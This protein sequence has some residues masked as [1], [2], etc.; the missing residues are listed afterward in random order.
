MY[1][2]F[3]PALSLKRSIGCREMRLSGSERIHSV[4]KKAGHSEAEE[5]IVSA[6]AEHSESGGTSAPESSLSPH[7]LVNLVV[8][9]FFLFCR[10]PYFHGRH[11]SKHKKKALGSFHRMP[12]TSPI[13]PGVLVTSTCPNSVAIGSHS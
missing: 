13:I 1:L 10:F 7:P 3:V 8:F 12:D 4:R 6:A 2:S 9:F 5:E 11:G